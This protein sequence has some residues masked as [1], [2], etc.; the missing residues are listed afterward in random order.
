MYDCGVSL[1]LDVLDAKWKNVSM[2]LGR[3]RIGIILIKGFE[4]LFEFGALM[5]LACI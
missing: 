2:F 5:R 3:N 4:P 1:R